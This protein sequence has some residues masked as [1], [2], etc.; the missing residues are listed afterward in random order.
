MTR[1]ATSLN[2]DA[3]A[4]VVNFASKLQPQSRPLDKPIVDR[5]NT[6]GTLPHARA[7]L[8]FA[9]I[10]M[11]VCGASLIKA[12]GREFFHFFRFFFMRRFGGRSVW[13]MMIC[14]VF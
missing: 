7:R 1:S 13:K 6:G 5:H 11:H 12:L 8:N 14:G 4:G 10:K 9:L 3:L 2:F